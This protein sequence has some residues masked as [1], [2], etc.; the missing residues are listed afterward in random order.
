MRSQNR[1]E[2]LGTEEA[3]TYKVF[4]PVAGGVLLGYQ[5][6]SKK[7]IEAKT[8]ISDEMLGTNQVEKV[9]FLKGYKLGS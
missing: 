8:F 7:W 1:V 9:E 5:Y 2:L 4:L 6:T 3:D